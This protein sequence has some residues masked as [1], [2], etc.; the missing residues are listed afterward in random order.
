M[1]FIGSIEAKIDTKGR[2]FLPAIFRKVLAASDEEKIVMRKDI[3]QP[4]LVLYPESIWNIQ[5][6]TLNSHLNRWNANHRQIF[7][8]FVSDAEIIELDGNGRFLIPKR[9]L[10]M[11]NIKQSIKF[12]GMDD[13]VEIWNNDNSNSQ[14]AP[15]EFSKQL[16]EI[17]N[18]ENC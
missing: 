5:L 18:I 16:E 12:I 8:Q 6:D 3:H 13:T 1:R 11:V 15:Q 2:A 9:Y 14:M 7:R 4:C 17:M 10:N